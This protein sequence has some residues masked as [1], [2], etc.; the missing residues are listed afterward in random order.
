MKRHV[1]ITIAVLTASN[2]FAYYGDYSSSQED[3]MMEK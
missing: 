1:L 2:S 3:L